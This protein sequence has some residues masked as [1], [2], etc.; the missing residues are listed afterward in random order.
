M[1][2]DVVHLRLNKYEWIENTLV[3]GTTP[4]QS[5]DLV[6]EVLSGAISC[7]EKKV[8]LCGGYDP[9]SACSLSQVAE[10]DFATKQWSKGIPLPEKVRDAAAIAFGDYCLVFGGWNDTSY[11]NNLW[12]FGPKNQDASIANSKESVSFSWTLVRPSDVSPCAR[13]CH[14]MVLGTMGGEDET[15]PQPVVYLFGG[16][17]GERRLND[18][19][20][21]RL[22]PVLSGGS[23]AWELVEAKSGTPPSPRDD[24]AVAFD[25]AGER[26]LVFGGF[27][28]SLRS[29]LHVLS[30]R[31]GA[32]GW[33]C[34]ACVG[35]PSRR[36]RC[37]AAVTG[38]HLVVCLGEDE[39]GAVGQLLQVTLTDRRWARLALERDDLAG[40]RGAVGCVSEKGRRV[41]LFGGGDPLHQHTSLL[42]L[43]LD[44]GEASTARKR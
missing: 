28:S 21:L 26:L 12:L 9:R 1:T 7:S 36:Q 20:R 2:T 39:R 8:Y 24:A 43:E 40:R 23:A 10:F 3:K 44:K 15:S 11:C 13:V 29:D 14:S 41:V 6:K 18:V 30:L 27:A 32:N 35:V 4:L 33:T 37:V 19:W 38:G 17:D 31:G 5:N 42:E 34:E 16:F 25:A 22:D